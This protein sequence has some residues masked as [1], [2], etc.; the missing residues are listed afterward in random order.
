VTEQHWALTL[1]ER[2]VQLYGE[3]IEQPMTPRRD[4]SSN[5]HLPP[6]TPLQMNQNSTG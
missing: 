2:Y 1:Y 5:D 4:E 3:P 6:N